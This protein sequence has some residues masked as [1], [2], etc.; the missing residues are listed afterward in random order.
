MP[1]GGALFGQAL[2]DGIPVYALG[3]ME[4]H[5]SPQPSRFGSGYGMVN[6]IPKFATR[7]GFDVRAGAKGG[8]HGTVAENFHLGYRN[9]RFDIFAAQTWISTDGHVAHSAARQAGYYANT[10]VQVAENWNIRFL[11]NYVQARTEV[12]HHP[13]GGTRF[14]ERYDTKTGFMTLTLANEFHNAS[15]WIK[16]YYNDTKFDLLGESGGAAWSRQTNRLFGLRGRELFSVWEN[17]EIVAGF[18]L[19]KTDLTN[20]NLN[21]V[22]PPGPNNPRTW[23]FP[24]QTVFSPF[25]AVNYLLGDRNG[26]YFIPSG[27]VRLFHNNVFDNAFAPHA[28]AVFGYKHT[29]AGFSYARAVNY[30]SPVVLQGFLANSSM[31][32]GFDTSVIKPETANHYE[33]G[34]THIKPG[35]FTVGAAY[36]HDR[37]RNRTRAYMFGAAPDEFFFTS[38]AVEYSV[39]GT[40]LTGRTVPANGL[41]IFAGATLLRAR[42][43]GDDGVEQDRL[44]YTPNF[45]FQAGFN[46]DL[47]RNFSLSGDYQHIRDMYA[48]TALRTS[49]TDNPASNFPALTEAHRLPNADVV[50]LRVEYAFPYIP[51]RLDKAR[52]FVAVDNVFNNKYAYA[53]ETNNNSTGYYYMPGTTFMAGI[54]FGF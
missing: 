1:R 6:F 35:K 51:A 19:D 4:I 54:D 26:F 9:G 25:A 47:P 39:S 15:G 50:N 34:V 17:G 28:G 3:G 38:T 31:P 49:P 2:A 16:A 24:D 44:P 12:P 7:E 33:I 22:N 8:S 14:A 45:T 21:F 23:N 32:E 40:E 30:P 18:D 43:K 20:F 27:G 48:G 41:E 53:L 42:G 36:F 5:K 29:E 46:W 13:L 10:G 52:F 37:G 11:G